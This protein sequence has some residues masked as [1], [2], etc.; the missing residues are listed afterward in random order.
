[1]RIERVV[2]KGDPRWHE[3]GLQCQVIME[4]IP[5]EVEALCEECMVEV[6]KREY[7]SKI[8]F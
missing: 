5:A 6:R 3:G 4:E 2:M 8:T 7:D 1:M